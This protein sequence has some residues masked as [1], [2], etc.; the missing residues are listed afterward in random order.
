MVLDHLAAVPHLD[1]VLVAVVLEVVALGAAALVVA[2][3]DAVALDAAVWVLSPCDPGVPRAAVMT[4][5]TAAAKKRIALH[6]HLTP[7]LPSEIYRPFY[8]LP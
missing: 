4:R 3:L 6:Q 5:M 2:V 1:V 7:C 8:F